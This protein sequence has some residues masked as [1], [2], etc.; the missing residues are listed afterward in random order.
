MARI[1]LNANIRETN[2]GTKSAMRTLR[3]SGSV[4]GVVYHKGEESLPI[5]LGARSLFEVLHTGAGRNVL[6]DL[7]VEGAKKAKPTRLVVIKEI[8]QNPVN[9]TVLH[10]DFHEVSLTEKIKIQVAIVVKGE[11]PGVKTEGGMLENS[12][13]ELEIECLPTDIPEHIV[14]DISGLALNQSIHV[15]D[16]KLSEKL[17]VLNE[18]DMVIVQV[19]LPEEVSLE[20]VPEGDE[21]KEPEVIM[22][23]KKEEGEEAAAGDAKKGGEAKSEKAEAKK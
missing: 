7:K 9:G 12:L 6:I 8:Q 16:L 5:Q 19:R 3:A 17:K 22:E 11:A 18:E 10:V 2:T 20:T 23:K 13:R 1:A 21:A 14:I 15:R 4:P